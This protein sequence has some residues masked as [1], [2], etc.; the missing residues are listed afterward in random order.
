MAPDLF[1]E[2]QSR[3]QRAPG[4]VHHH[5]LQ[6]GQGTPVSFHLPPS[7]PASHVPEMAG[8]CEEDTLA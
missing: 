1:R 5:R 6:Q 4:P 7:V 8:A 3:Q 2:I